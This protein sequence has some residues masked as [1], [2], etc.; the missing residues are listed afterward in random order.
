MLFISSLVLGLSLGLASASPTGG[1]NRGCSAIYVLT[2]KAE[3]G[4]AAALIGRDGKIIAG[5]KTT[6]TGGAG[7][8]GIDGS[9]KQPA[10]P[11]ALFSQSAL[12][13]AKGVS[14]AASPNPIDRRM[15]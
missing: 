14:T 7:A 15:R 13:I 2:N 11:D 8:N 6:A 4:V 12:T 3:N 10:K 5:G 9:N 1:Q